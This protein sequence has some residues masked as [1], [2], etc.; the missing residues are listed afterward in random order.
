[1]V[2]AKVAAVF[3][4]AVYAGV[5]PDVR[6]IAAVLAEFHIVNVRR[7]ARLIRVGFANPAAVLAQ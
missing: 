3:A 6:A 5:A 7:C 4:K 1:M 2:Q